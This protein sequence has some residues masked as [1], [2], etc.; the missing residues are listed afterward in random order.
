MAGYLLIHGGAS[1]SRAW[2]RLLPL[3]PAPALAPDLP[4]RLDRPADL[5]TVTLDGGAASVAADV[6]A[7]P[8]A[9][10]A[11]LVVVAHSSGGLFVPGI[12]EALGA[13]RV[14]AL[15]LHAASV[16]PEG[17][18]GL[19]CMQPR[20]AAG[21][22]AAVEQAE[23][24]GRTL[25]TPIPKA[26]SMRTSSGEELTDEQLAFVTDPSRLVADSVGV[27]FQPVH[28]SVTADVPTTYIVSLRDG[29]VPPPLQREMAAR[30]PGQAKAIEVDAGH[31]LAVTD[32]TA[33]AEL[34]LA[35]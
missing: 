4:G 29:A 30:L 14:R 17:G 28:Y 16:P 3:L 25:T 1:T 5:G 32:P 12:V 33:L 6:A 35:V 2:D 18:T 10:E 31:L 20:H 15:V 26:E 23:A 19:D 8:L 24:S 27:Y 13:D 21:L 22:R 34:I 7:S 11:E 9:D